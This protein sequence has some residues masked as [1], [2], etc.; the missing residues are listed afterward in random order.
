[1]DRNNTET[2]SSAQNSQNSVN[3]KNTGNIKEAVCIDAARV[4]DSCSSKEYFEDMRVFFTPDKHDLI[5]N[6]TNVRIRS[7]EVIKVFLHLEPVPFNQGFYAID[8]NFFFDVCLDV[9]L[10]QSACPNVLHG[11]CL[12]NKRVILF[13]SDGNVKTF[14]SGSAADPDVELTTGKVLPKSICRISEPIGLSAKICDRPPQ[15]CDTCH[16]IPDSISAMYGTEF[17]YG[18]SHAIYATIGLFTIVHLVRNIP[19]LIPSYEFSIPEQ[20][21][22]PTSDGPREMFRRIEFPTE[23]FFPPK[24]SEIS[25]K[26]SGKEEHA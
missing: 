20:E 1:M 7:A 15:G 18:C 6:A 17:D 12:A 8:M 4:Y 5:E 26:K 24:V 2:I 10:P 13:G 19:L 11:V 3:C 16:G 9:F 21:Y 23:D 14:V 22:Q 25:S